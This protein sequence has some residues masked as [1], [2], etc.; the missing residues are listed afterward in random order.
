[1]VKLNMS[2]VEPNMIS[3]DDT[4][5]KFKFEAPEFF[6]F[7]FNV[8]DK[9][10]EDTGKLAMFWA[11]M[12]GKEEK[13][14]FHDFKILSNKF[15]N[16]LKNL[17][18]E[19]G[20]RIILMLP[21]MPQ[22]H[23]AIVGAMKLNAISIPAPTLLTSKDI[24]YRLKTSEAKAAVVDIENAVKF[25]KVKELC[26]SLKALIVVGGE[27]T[28]WVSYDEEMKKASSNLKEKKTKSSDATLIFF[29]S[30]TVGPP[31]TVVHTHASYPY[32]HQLTGRFWLDLKPSDLHWNL[33][34]T[35][36]AKAAWSSLFG[37]WNMGACIFNFDVRGRFDAIATL[38]TL[39]RYPIT[40]FCAPP[41]AF[42]M[43]IKEDL[44]SYKLHLRHV[45]SAGEPLNPEV[46]ETW[47]KGTGLLI[48]EGYGQTES[49]N[50]LANYRCMKVKHG[51]TGKPVPSFYISIVDENGNE[52]GPNVEGDIAVKIKPQRP[53]GLFV[54]YYKDPERTE[55]CF[56]GNW[57]IT[58]D[59]GYKDEEGYFCFVGRADDVIK[60]S[61]YR[62]GPFEVESALVEHP[63]VVEAAV[64]GVPDEL[65]GSIVK[66]FIVLRKGY[67]PSERLVKELQEHVKNVTAPYKYPREIEFVEELP[68]TIS[69]KIRRVE[70]RQRETAKR[71]EKKPQ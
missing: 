60:S 26:P 41:T 31:K 70:L 52:V 37:P 21:R 1:M 44:K 42:R 15:A 49:V 4:Y 30:G 51:S 29:T 3:Y 17:G 54:G 28:G 9:W 62:I 6:N 34:D 69:G 48:Y 50:L 19:E 10:A 56:R 45:V 65:R 67:S 68:K 12:E 2:N 38:T 46:I 18:V 5:R 64:I 47:K 7:G 16:I 39:E 11:N 33:S 20:D 8:V 55:E 43:M 53:V 25:D 27:K 63:A 14:T 66:A 35:G 23:V 61:G 40:T 71:V 32:A 22:W 24:E 13:Y 36:W 59:R 57:Y 58:G